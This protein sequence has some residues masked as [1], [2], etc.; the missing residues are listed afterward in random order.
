MTV[1]NPNLAFLDAMKT[2]KRYALLQGGTRSGKTFSS[3]QFIIR[4]CKQIEGM[5]AVISICRKTMPSLKATVMRDFFDIL[6]DLGLYNEAHHNKTDANYTLFGNLIEFV[7]LDDEQKVRGRK[8]HMLYVNE[9]NENS[10]DVIR[11]L[12]FR[13]SGFC[14]F[15]Y[16]PTITEDHWLIADLLKRDNSERI[17]TNY[18]HNPFLS[19]AQIQEIEALKASDPELWKV[20][21]EG[22]IGNALR[23]LVFP[24]WE[25]GWHE[26]GRVRRAF[27]LDFGYSPDPLALVEVVIQGMN[28][29]LR[30]HIY[31]TNIEVDDMA[32]HVLACVPRG[33]ETFCDHRQELI[34][35]LHRRGVNTKPA[36]KGKDSID[37]GIKTMKKYRIFVHPDS[38]DLARELKY[39][40]YKED[41][42]GN[43]IG[44]KYSESLNHAI[45]AARYGLTGME[46][47]HQR[48]SNMIVSEI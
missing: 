15:D 45:D 3:I 37:T 21:G 46:H 20:F 36:I 26:E 4:T 29:Y 6:N 43:P 31:K 39:Y 24:D 11:Q 13:T 35:L 27:G 32:N 8:R 22:K 10:H 18:K 30:Q 34:N 19:E 44:G 16:N 40:R 2:Q 7:N 33:T 47:T 12:L 41:K 38:K 28:L 9:A 14:I 48:K 23:G 17:I 5:G 1:V 25:Y 42:D